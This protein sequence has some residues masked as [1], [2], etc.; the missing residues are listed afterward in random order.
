L[1]LLTIELII[2]VPCSSCTYSLK[3]LVWLKTA[4]AVWGGYIGARQGKIGLGKVVRERFLSMSP[5]LHVLV[6]LLAS[7]HQ[8]CTF[9]H[10]F[11]HNF[12]A[13]LG[14][15]REAAKIIQNQT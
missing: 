15:C 11:G 7:R 8:F 9:W 3:N 5:I 4:F 12:A 6:Q 13:N 10:R 1:V 2:F 14:A